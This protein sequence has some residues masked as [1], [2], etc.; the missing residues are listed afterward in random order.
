MIFLLSRKRSSLKK[1]LFRSLMSFESCVL[2]LGETG[3]LMKGPFGCQ[4]LQMR[5]LISCAGLSLLR[6]RY[7]MVGEPMP[8]N[9]LPLCR[10]NAFNWVLH[11]V[12]EIWHCVGIES[13]GFEEQFMALLTAIEVGHTQLKKSDSKKQRKLKRWTWSI[14]YKGSSSRER[15]IGRG[16]DWHFFYEAQDRISKFPRA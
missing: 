9:S 10:P 3:L 1:R 14:Y 5:L 2:R 16:G 11:K 12:K 8:L 15:S 6:K 7:E 4:Y 13:V